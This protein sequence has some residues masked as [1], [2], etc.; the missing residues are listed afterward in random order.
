MGLYPCNIVVG[1]GTA[2][3]FTVFRRSLASSPYQHI[4]YDAP[5]DTM[6]EGNHSSGTYSALPEVTTYMPNS[7]P[8]TVTITFK[9][10]GYYRVQ[11]SESATP[12]W[13]YKAI[14]ETIQAPLGNYVP[15]FYYSDLKRH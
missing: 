9:M 10:A 12:S 5:T 6:T 13:I 14:N 8:F 1:E 2:L 15:L 11:D 4:R 7:S 3:G